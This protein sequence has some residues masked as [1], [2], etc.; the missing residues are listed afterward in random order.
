MLVQ[1]NMHPKK[2]NEHLHGNDHK[3]NHMD[4]YFKIVM[5]E[6]ISK[7]ENCNQRPKKQNNMK[8]ILPRESKMIL[9]ERL[10]IKVHKWCKNEK[11][12]MDQP[13][14]VSWRWRQ[15][16]NMSNGME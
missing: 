7:K 8:H 3:K 6:Y 2:I 4:K 10:R 9:S 14:M 12:Y 16:P 11:I 5:M 1:N 15:R 13:T